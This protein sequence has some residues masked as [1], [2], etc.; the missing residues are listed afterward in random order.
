MLLICPC[1]DAHFPCEIWLDTIS[2]W[3]KKSLCFHM[4]VSAVLL[5]IKYKLLG[6]AVTLRNTSCILL[7]PAKCW[8]AEFQVSNGACLSSIRSPCRRP[9][10]LSRKSIIVHGPLYYLRGVESQKLLQ[11]V[12]QADVHSWVSLVGQLCLLGLQPSFLFL[13]RTVPLFPKLVPK[14]E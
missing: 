7:G 1:R 11:I 6:K 2:K 14:K 10:I 3:S 13:K 12:H 5:V 8:L 4:W 9:N